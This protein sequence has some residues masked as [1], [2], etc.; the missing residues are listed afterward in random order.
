LNHASQKAREIEAI[1][2]T[3]GEPGAF[4]R[5]RWSTSLKAAWTRLLKRMGRPTA[6]I[7]LDESFPG[8]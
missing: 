2:V 1:T 3:Y 7:A 8:L 5:H 4:E 6:C